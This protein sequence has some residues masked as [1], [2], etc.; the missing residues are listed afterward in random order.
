MA[1]YCAGEIPISATV[2]GYKIGSRGQGA[3]TIGLGNFGD[4]LTALAH[5][6]YN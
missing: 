4:L 2:N 3:Q 1:Q 5:V 6:F